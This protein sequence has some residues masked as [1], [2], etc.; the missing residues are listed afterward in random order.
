MKKLLTIVL[1]IICATCFSLFFV[2][3]NNKDNTAKEEHVHSPSDWVIDEEATCLEKGLKHKECNVCNSILSVAMTSAL[4]HN[5]VNNKCVNCGEER[6]TQNLHYAINADG[7]SYRLIGIGLASD[8]DVVVPSTYNGLPVTS[9]GLGAFEDC[10]SLVS[11]IIP[12]SV[13]SIVAFAFYNCK[14]LTSIV[15]PD[16]VESIGERAFEGCTSLTSVYYSD[17][18]EDWNNISIGRY[19]SNLTSAT[20][21]YYIENESDLPNDNGN[22]WHYVDGVPTIWN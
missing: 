17:T 14:S 21:Y 2:A 19:N 5:Y 18:K 11:I 16:S 4:G 12:D 3:C 15:I 13:T 8:R 6:Y 1:S 7:K 9:I 10:T 20:R 22:Y